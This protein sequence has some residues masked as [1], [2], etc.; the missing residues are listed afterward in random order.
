MAEDF[1]SEVL[2][3]RN[4]GPEILPENQ[5]LWAIGLAEEAGEVLG[6]LKKEWY[7]GHPPNDE[8]F[9][10]E[11]GDVLFYLTCLMHDRGYR[12]D[13]GMQACVKKLRKRYPNGFNKID[14]VNRKD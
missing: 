14:S 7:H 8:K 1:F 4:G 6:V 3:R 12:L 13:D 5:P 11:C 9:L 10:S 2:L